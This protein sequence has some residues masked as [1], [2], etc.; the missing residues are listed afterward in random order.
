MS[1]FP[2]KEIDILGIG[3]ST[4]DRFIVVDHYPTGREVQQ[5]VSSTTD[6]GGP[7]ATALAVAGKYGARTAMIDSIGDDMVGR[8]I[9][10]DFEKYNVNTN[11]IQ[12]ESGTNSGVATI[13]VKQ[14]TGERAVFFERSTATEPDF[15]EVHKQ[16]IEDAYIL[17]INGR[18]RQLMRSAM[19]V[20]KEAG[21]IISLDGGAQRYDED[22]KPITEDSHIVIVARD[23]AEKYTGTTNLEDACRIIHDRG[24]LIAG[25]TDG[26]N[27]S[28]FVWP[29]GTAYCC[30]PFPQKSIVDTTGAG[31]SFHGAF[32]ANLAHIINHMK[33]QETIST[34][35][36]HGASIRAVELLKHCAHS[37]LEKAAIFAS[38]VAS[39]NTQ[40]IGGRSPLPTLQSVQELIG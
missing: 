3:A 20:A 16:L 9:L 33:E 18:H 12:V 36:S 38:A 35:K 40:G 34:S 32:L 37:D 39:L 28:Y 14:S 29:D 4:L 6:G 24:A 10:D 27:G 23:Y 31:D 17:H 5:V 19:A 21:T 1:T 11:A 25:V 13:L 22:M 8:H 26:A 7:V 30:E 2:Q 15:L